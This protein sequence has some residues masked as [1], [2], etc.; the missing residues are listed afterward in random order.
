MSEHSAI[1]WTDATWNPVRGCKKVSPGCDHCYAERFAE[2]WRGIA[3]HAYEA[4]FDP[5]YVPDQLTEPLRWKTPRN[6][7]VNSMSDLL[8]GAFSDD[9]IDRVFAVMA[10]C[11]MHETKPSHT[12]QILTKRSDRMMRYTRTNVAE[13]RRR[14]GRI[15]GQLMEDGDAWADMVSTRMPWPLPNVHL[16][17]SVESPEYMGRITD[18]KFSEAAVRFLSLEPLLADMGTLDLAGIH[19]VIVGGESGPGARPMDLNWARHVRDQC[20]YEHVPF[21]F[22][23]VGG[24]L[25]K[26]AGRLLDGRTHDEMPR[27]AP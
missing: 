12:F 7:F 27:R 2:R 4:G 23:Q 20:E 1:E 25:K 21:F 6:V 10:I 8:Q 3:G 11:A 14:L 26:K 18:L 5:R 19:W 22:K 15:A 16:G 17:V 24:V 13:L 9:I